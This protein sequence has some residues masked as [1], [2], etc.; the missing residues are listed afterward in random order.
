MDRLAQLLKEKAKILDEIAQL[1]PM[2][3]GTVY[4]FQPSSVR[5]DGART[6]R[7]PYLKYT[8]KK[9]NKTRGKHLRSAAEAE[10]YRRQ[11]AQF[12]RFEDLTAQL[13]QVGERLADLEAGE[14]SCKK[15]S[16]S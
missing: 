16:S 13:T 15:N 12:R 4:A 9:N 11:I 1:G 7:G 14:R 6:F 8:L 10:L 5:K 3:R 2:R